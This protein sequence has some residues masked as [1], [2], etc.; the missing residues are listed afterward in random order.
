MLNKK[1]NEYKKANPEATAKQIAKELGT[2]TAY[3][4]QTLSS[5][6]PK[7]DKKE[8]MLVAPTKGQQVLRDEI[9]RLHA[10][11]A[12]WQILNDVNEDL[13]IELEEEINQLKNDVIGYRAVISYLQGQ[14]DGVTV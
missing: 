3:V 11:M 2:S 4:Y 12:N 1:I 10:E 5:K 6:K 13:V 8:K 7:K 14:L 9:E